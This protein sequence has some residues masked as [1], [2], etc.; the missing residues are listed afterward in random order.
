MCEKIFESKMSNEEEEKEKKICSVV[1]EKVGGRSSVITCLSRY[2][3]K[4]IIP[5]KVFIFNNRLFYAYAVEWSSLVRK[6][7][8]CKFAWH[9]FFFICLGGS[10]QNWC[11]LGLCSQLWRWNCICKFHLFSGFSPFTLPWYMV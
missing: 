7:W 2:P 5:K 4:F 8:L 3:L 10:F 11:S 1:V 9:F 6:Y